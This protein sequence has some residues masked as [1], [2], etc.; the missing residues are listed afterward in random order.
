[1]TRTPKIRKRSALAVAALASAGCV[2]HVDLE[3]APNIVSTQWSS[4]AAPAAGPAGP[5]AMPSDL[6]VAFHS[7]ELSA[8]IARA[9][10]ANTD[11]AIAAARIR[12]ARALLRV[13]RGAMLPA[14]SASAGG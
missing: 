11:V 5:E 4:Q 2:P 6:G 3:V 7:A 13:A 12:Q 10:S 9:A 1:M 8:L 14:V